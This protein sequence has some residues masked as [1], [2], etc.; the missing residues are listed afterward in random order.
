MSHGSFATAINC[1]DGRTQ[2]PV[3]T[4][5]KKSF[6]VDY[7]DMI[8]EPGP[9]KVFL[10]GGEGYRAA[11]K[12]K[13]LISINVH[14]SRVLAIAGHHDCAGNPG[15]KDQH[16]QQTREV[17]ETIGSWNLGVRIVG[18]WVDENWNVQKVYESE[19]A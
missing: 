4:W 6:N 16:V 15:S 2:E 13:I 17:A 12:E 3:I 9:K 19:P 5:V 1:M 10:T 14:G 11:L 18:L 8:T 7:V